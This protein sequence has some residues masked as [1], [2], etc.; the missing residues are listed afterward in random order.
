MKQRILNDQF[1]MTDGGARSLLV[2]A[3]LAVFLALSA[4]VA[5]AMT[6]GRPWHPPRKFNTVQYS[7]NQWRINITNYGT[8]GY[9]DQ[10]PGGEWPAGSGDMYIYGAGIWIGT[11]KKTAGGRDTLVSC[12]YNPNSGKSEMTPGCY[13]NAPGGYAGREYERVYIYPDDWPPKRA[14]FKYLQ[15][16]V[17]TPL[18]VPSGDTTIKGYFYYVPQ[19]AV[20]SGDAWAVFNDR[21]PAQH[22]AGKTP[23]PEGVEV[24]QT[25]YSWALPWNRDIVFFKLDVRNR[26]TTTLKDVY[27]GMVCDADIG[28]AADDMAGLALDKYIYNSAG[29][30]SVHVDNMGYAWSNDASPGGLIGF[31]FLQSPFKKDAQGNIRG[32]PDT[33]TTYPD[34]LDDNGNGLIDEPSEGEQIG[35]TSFKIFTLT[36]A[37]PKDDYEQYLAMA[38]YDYGN[39]QHP[40]NP[41]DSSDAAPADKRFLQATGPFDLA[42]NEIVTVTIGVIAADRAGSERNTMPYNLALASQAAQQAYDNNW[43]APEPPPSPN[44]TALPGD[45]RVA[46]VWDNLPESA[47]D[48]FFPLSR[49]LASPYYAEQDFQGYKVYRSRT[50][51]PNSWQLL[52]QYDRNDGLRF[53]DTTVVESLRTKATDAGLSYSYVD[54]SHLRLGFPYYY[55][56]TSFDINFLGGRSDT[57][58]PVPPDTLSLESGIAPVRAV[59]RTQPGNFHPPRDSAQLVAGNPDLKLTV[60]PLPLVPYAVKAE[61]YRIQFLGP[62]YDPAS[63]RPLYRYVVTDRAG[64]TVVPENQFTVAIDTVTDTVRAVPT[65]FDSV[66][67]NIQT[68]VTGTGDTVVDTSRAWLPI[69]Q[70]SMKLK[71]D[72]IPK[73]FYDRLKVVSG[74]YPESTLK[75]PDLPQNKALWA[76]RGSDYR[77]V[78]QRRGSAVTV[79]VYDMDN[80]FTVP[81]RYFPYNAA[82]TDSADGWAFRP[83]TSS[84]EDTFVVGRTLSM[85]IVGSFFLFTPAVTDT[86]GAGDTWV[87]YNK[88]LSPAPFFAAIEAE[89][90]PGVLTDTSQKLRVKAV[91]N[92]YVMSNE[93]ERHHDFRKL[94]FINLPNRCTIRIYNMAGDLVR[95][96]EHHDTK[97]DVGG[98]PGLFGGD[99]DW[100]LLNESRQKPAPGTYFFHVESDVGSQL[101]KFVLIF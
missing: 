36:D 83:S 96:L 91:P 84:A 55:A 33:T 34:G 18:R 51:Q 88:L 54:S 13:D 4:G 77:L 63:L 87:L 5:R 35:M 22:V 15:D 3:C 70:M 52:A 43:I 64:S 37:D 60:E 26:D 94:K 45:G 93:W 41:Y 47:R 29:S 57:T 30:D 66:I 100:D 68:R 21:D 27:I 74:H 75:I 67:T 71:M 53:E 82:A 80:G 58:P 76:Y 6:A 81:Y 11:L 92:P 86:P 78:W 28:N 32:W 72:R 23:R 48:R 24:Y 19:D 49:S 42:P 1:L 69:V 40:Y 79:E 17:L 20:S 101:G 98:T 90:S 85:Y 7:K 44:V 12:G 99:E 39:P 16:S 46:L 31:D 56:V 95:T 25:T 50:G 61:K 62:A 14:D 73:Q 59:P 38:G 65:V 89:F 2:A 97:P 10:K 8:F 9:G